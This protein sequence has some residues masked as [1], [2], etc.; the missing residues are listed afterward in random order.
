MPDPAAV[1]LDTS[2]WVAALRGADE[3]TTRRV[4]QLLRAGRVVICGPVLFE[5][6]RGLRPSE[7][8]RVLP[9]LDAVP[10]LHLEEQEWEA[11]AELDGDLRQRGVTL[12]PMDVLIAQ[13]ARRHTVPLY[14]LDHHFDEIPQLDRYP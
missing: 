1:L 7:R 9:L 10:R 4:Q 6:R 8:E 2:V 14:T 12:P 13:V 3:K 11:A 5:L